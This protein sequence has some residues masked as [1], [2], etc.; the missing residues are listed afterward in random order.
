MEP[1]ATVV[2]SGRTD[3]DGD[4]EIA[5][6]MPAAAAPGLHLLT[7]WAGDERLD[8]VPAF[9][10]GTKA[11]AEGADADGDG[12]ADDCDSDPLDGPNAD[13]DGDGKANEPDNCPLVANAAQT[14]TDGDY[15]G[16]ACDPDQGADRAARFRNGGRPVPAAPAAP[17]NVTA[18][19][20]GGRG[21]RHLGAARDAARPS[22]ATASRAG[23]RTVDVGPDARSATLDGLA[24][25]S[26]VR[27]GV[28]AL[29]RQ[30]RGADRALGAGA[31]SA[32]PAAPR[33]RR[34]RQRP[35]SRRRRRRRRH[36][37]APAAKPTISF[38]GAPKKIKLSRKRT[39][40]AALQGH[41]G[42]EGH[43]QA[44]RHQARRAPS[45]PTPRATSS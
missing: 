11:C 3:A 8:L 25:G 15:E 20:E 13:A 35:P 40:V 43:L 29:A 26:D 14:D 22:P 39:F 21:D 36:H 33:R 32:T 37:A 31:V 23:G 16:D 41:P 34:R 12:L 28:S 9:V 44:H 38:K 7:V 19:V 45:R 30:R 6:R 42:P 18:R 4:A 1:L 17:R 27:I 5:I 10:T 2:G 24:P